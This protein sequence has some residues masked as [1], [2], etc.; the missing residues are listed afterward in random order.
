M[1][2]ADGSAHP[3]RY[4]PSWRISTMASAIAVCGNA[5]LAP[6]GAYFDNVIVIL[7]SHQLE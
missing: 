1:G 4:C 2:F 7:T 5:D 6:R 3:I